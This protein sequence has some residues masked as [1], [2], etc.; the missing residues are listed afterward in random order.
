MDR[1]LNAFELFN[2]AVES[3]RRA[4]LPGALVLLRGGFFENLYVAPILL[5]EEFHLQSIWHPGPQAEPPA[6]REYAARYGRLWEA[7][8]RALEVLSAVWNDSLVRAELRSFINLSK[9]LFN[10]RTDSE[11]GD[12]FR[13]RELFLS[14][15]RLKRT[16]SEIL[17]RIESVRSRVP[18]PRPGLALIMLASRDPTASVEFYRKLLGIVPAAT[19]TQ[20]G[21]YAEFELDGVRLAI[22]GKSDAAADDP[23]LLGPQPASF[24]WG[25]VFVFRVADFDRYYENARSESLEIVDQAVATDGCRSFV[26]KDPSGY[27][28]EVT[29]EDPKGLDDASEG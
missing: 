8:P 27:L 24:G 22:H 20:A 25:A 19:S 16:Q 9:N 4:D 2:A 17:G 11:R 12:L 21:G 29:E 5:G 14:P 6:A 10:A 13:E 3:L 28:L 7:N 18:A 15:E 26:V 1:R 23:Y